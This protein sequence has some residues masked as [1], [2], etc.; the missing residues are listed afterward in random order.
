MPLSELRQTP[1]PPWGADL[2]RPNVH[3]TLSSCLPLSRFFKDEVSPGVI[4]EWQALASD[5]SQARPGPAQV[6]G[7]R[8]LTRSVYV[9]IPTLP[10]PPGL[11]LS[12]PW[13]SQLAA[14]EVRRGGSP[15]ALTL[16]PGRAALMPS[17]H[18]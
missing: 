11:C 7:L 2:S 5:V 18:G 13:A 16:P 4:R 12:F 8:F 15:A 14:C 9:Y 6:L 1:A 3:P 10:V 17:S